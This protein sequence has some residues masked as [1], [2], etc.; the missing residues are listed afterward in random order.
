MGSR[1]ALVVLVW[2]CA[3]SMTHAILAPITEP[4]WRKSP[5]LAA[6]KREPGSNARKEYR[7][8]ARTEIRLNG[9]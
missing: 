3:T 1:Y 9:I 5:A 8:D 4:D 7:V 2:V 6:S